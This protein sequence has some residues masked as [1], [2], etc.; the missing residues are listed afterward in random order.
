MEELK[1]IHDILN[2]AWKVIREHK[3][4]KATLSEDD[5]E[6][7][8]LE[9]NKTTKELEHEYGLDERKLFSGLYNAMADYLGKKE[10]NEK[11]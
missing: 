3:S 6:H 1:M 11:S 4:G 2:M 7:M 8:L 9:A 10:K 5:W